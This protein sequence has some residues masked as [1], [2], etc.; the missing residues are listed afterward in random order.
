MVASDE[1]GQLLSCY[2]MNSKSSD[3]HNKYY[4]LQVLKCTYSNSY[5]IHTRYGRVGSTASN[6]MESSTYEN[7][8]KMYVKTYK[9]KTGSGKGY[10]AIAM[11]LGGQGNVSVKVQ[12]IEEGSDVKY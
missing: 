8:V 7:A 11:K 2:L 12:K 5:F 10:T 4:I 3:N 6:S 9:Q 1:N